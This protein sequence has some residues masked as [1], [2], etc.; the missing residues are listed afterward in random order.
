MILTVNCKHDLL[1]AVNCNGQIF[2]SV[3]CKFHSLK[4]VKICKDIKALRQGF[5]ICILQKTHQ[6]ACGEIYL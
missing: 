6:N 3:K 1:N 2:N 4:I 5:E